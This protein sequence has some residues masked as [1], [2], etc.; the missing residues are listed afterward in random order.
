[1]TAKEFIKDCGFLVK[2]TEISKFLIDTVKL[3]HKY[4]FNSKGACHDGGYVIFVRRSSREKHLLCKITKEVE[5]ELFKVD[6]A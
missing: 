2:D 3:Y 1:M 6:P 5:D 4:Y